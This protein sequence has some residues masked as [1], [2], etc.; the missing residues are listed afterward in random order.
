MGA[1]E[2][3][4]SI[5][6]VQSCYALG[7]QAEGIAAAALLEA[8]DPAHKD[9]YVGWYV[10]LLLSIYMMVTRASQLRRYDRLWKYCWDVFIDHKYGAWYRTLSPD[11]KKV[12]C[13]CTLN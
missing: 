11:N 8:A 7:L 12:G 2:S 13:A 9:N 1:G 5:T 10:N 6:W 3:K 4:L